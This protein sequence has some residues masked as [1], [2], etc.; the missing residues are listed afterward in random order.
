MVFITQPTKEGETKE[1]PNC[2][3]DLVS[4][5]SDYRGRFPDK[6]LWQSKSER[7]AHYDKNGNCN[8]ES[9]ISNGESNIPSQTSDEFFKNLQTELDQ[10]T[11]DS[12]DKV[13]KLIVSVYNDDELITIYQNID[14]LIAL[15]HII[16]SKFEEKGIELNVQ[17]IGMYMKLIRGM[18][19]D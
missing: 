11:R 15:E 2:K 14:R 18:S 6:I 16:K 5:L 19:E 7:K 10:E 8:K 17:K 3:V 13:E 12:D 9:D 1:C 4:R